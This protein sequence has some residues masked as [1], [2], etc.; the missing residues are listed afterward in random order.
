MW[1]CRMATC[2][3][4]GRQ[5]AILMRMEK[6]DTPIALPQPFVRRMQDMLG[7]NAQDFLATYE[8]PPKRAFRLR[9]SPGPQ[10]L[11]SDWTRDPVAWAS[12]SYYFDTTQDV[13]KHPAQD[14][15]A[16]YIQEPSAMAV[17]AAV[18]A[19]P[20][21]RILD[22][23][24][25]PGGKTCAVADAMQGQG[26]LVSNEIVPSRARTLARNVE[27]MGLSHVVVLSE[28]PAT[29]A[30]RFA[31]YFDK[32]I[33]DAPC[34][35]EGMFRKTPAA[36]E[37][38]SPEAVEACAVRQLEILESACV[39]LHVG[40]ELFYSTCTFSPQEN[41]GVISEFLY[42]HPEFEL[43]PLP[44]CEGAENGNA[45]YVVRPCP[46]IG[47]T[48]RLYPHRLR[49]EGHFLARLILTD[50]V[51]RMSDRAARPLPDKQT[52]AW[53]TFCKD[54]LT[55][56]PVATLR[57]GDMLCA[58]QVPIDMDGLHVLRA[59][60]HL[61]QDIRGRFEPDHAL[62]AWLDPKRACRRIDLQ[63][64]EQRL[65]RYLRGETCD[66]DQ[67]GWG[68]VSAFGLSAGWFK[69]DGMTAK[70]HFPKGLRRN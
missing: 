28:H 41:E 12:N 52:A 38:W 30:K 48:H 60:L 51:P 4:F 43:A 13:G 63:E 29:I 10:G 54:T 36:R 66:C 9:L 20:G 46:A 31:G 55:E 25:A 39:T 57:R 37:E 7:S 34:S 65:T 16:Y 62:A 26:I 2:L 69:S 45:D 18:N 50:G 22:L 19:Q 11:P 35:G 67:K 40:G 32:V 44:L 14:I 58:L 47:L 1:V 8:M 53:Q 15:G 27:R 42:R 5:N 68:V 21:E 24:A 6:Q 70:N 3:H 56:Y 61:G 17:A 49:G 64:D 59:G 33:V 23:C